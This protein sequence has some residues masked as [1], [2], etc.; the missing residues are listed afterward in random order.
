MGELIGPIRSDIDRTE[1]QTGPRARQITVFEDRVEKRNQLKGF[2]PGRE[3]T[4]RSKENRAMS[5][6]LTSPCDVREC[7]RYRD[8][9]F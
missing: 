5:I 8:R 6:E 3:K 4:R 7:S 2:S 1:D 9:P